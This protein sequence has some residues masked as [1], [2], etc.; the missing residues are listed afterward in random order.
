MQFELQLTNEKRALPS[1]RA[2][3][4]STL[5]QLPLS[6][7]DARDLASFVVAA[8]E[9]AIEH[10][11]PSG[12]EGAI[13]LSLQEKAGRLEI[14]IRD[15]GLPI[16]AKRWEREL[17]DPESNSSNVFGTHRPSLVDE[18]HWISFGPE[19]K[20][21]QLIKWLASQ[22][23]A[24]Q[25]DASHLAPFQGDAP[26]APP[27]EYQIRRMQPDEAVQV[28]Q[29]MYRAYGGTYFNADVYFP[30]RI[31][32]L[33]AHGALLSIVAQA[34][35]GAIVGHCALEFNQAGPV[36]E[37][38]QAIV[39][40]AH[41]SRGLLDRMKTELLK[42]GTG[43]RPL[44]AWY[45]DA[46]AVHTRTQKSDAEHGGK[47]SAVSL[48]ISPKTE[49]F[50][51]IADTQP[52]RVSCL[53]Y[54]HWL[55][56][57][58]Q[59]TVYAPARHREMIARLYER[60]GAKADFA[61]GQAP[62]GHGTLT[63]QCD[64]GGAKAFIRVSQAGDDT[65]HAIRHAKRRLIERAHAELIFVE[66]L[67]SDPATPQIAASLEAAGFGFCGVAPQFSPQGDVLR[68]A[69]LVEPLKRDPIK[70][71]EPFAG[72]LVDYVLADQQRVRAL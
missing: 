8:V 37:L 55:L 57:P 15:F 45:G 63:V 48:G 17:H 60:L 70:T 69:Y 21:L 9:S 32:A 27:Q 25:L 43:H 10:A 12:E 61:E 14:Q 29:L 62:S 24:D 67:L 11:Y 65:V 34:A 50:R 35:D 58:E 22:H 71:Y 42:Q 6:E 41:R 4:D 28:S 3:V 52:Q 26:L 33:N 38:G 64:A 54:I 56:E 16:D 49:R 5:K 19:G 36:A 1:V 7:D 31:A 20:A 18:A 51:N 59:R 46:V 53:L 23:I 68:L 66:L 2:F 72:E 39:D 47:L 44:A 30:E 40:P 13:R